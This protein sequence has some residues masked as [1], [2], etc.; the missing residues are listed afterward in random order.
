MVKR[1]KA[2]KAARK[3]AKLCENGTLDAGYL[4]VKYRWKDKMLRKIETK[5]A[6]RKPSMET[7]EE[8]FGSFF[9]VKSVFSIVY[10]I[11]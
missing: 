2:W 10:N 11:H 1:F 4:K 3:G 6:W 8:Y 7:A 5:K 9:D